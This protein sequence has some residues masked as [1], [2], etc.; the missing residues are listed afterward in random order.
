MRQK[1]FAE[2]SMHFTQS[3]IRNPVKYLTWSVLRKQLTTFSCL[4]FLE[5][6]PFQIFDRVVDAPMATDG[7]DLDSVFAYWI[8]CGGGGGHMPIIKKSR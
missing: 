6:A 3:C 2:V 7:C 5:N 8:G 4:L 1:Q